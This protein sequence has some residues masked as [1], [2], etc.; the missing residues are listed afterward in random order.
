MRRSFLKS[1]LA[2]VAVC[3]IN[4]MAADQATTASATTATTEPPVKVVYDV[5]EGLEQASR[6]LANVRNE[7]RA[8]PNSKIVVVTHG[9]GIK[10]LLDGAVDSRNRQFEA[11]VSALASQGVEF[12]VCNNTLN[13]FS[14]P[15]SKVILEAKVVP[16][17][18][19]EV[20]RLQSREGYAYIHP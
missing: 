18:V 20:A 11:I 7:L 9:E 14:I 6:A 16:S 1:L 10:F 3:S 15:T 4:V 13:A 19:A 5:S 12:R 17:G 2:L 8:E